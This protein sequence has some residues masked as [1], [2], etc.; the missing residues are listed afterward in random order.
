CRGGY[1]D[2]SGDGQGRKDGMEELALWPEIPAPRRG[3]GLEALAAGQTRPALRSPCLSRIPA[4]QGVLLRDIRPVAQPRLR[5]GS[6]LDR[7]NP[8]HQCGRQRGHLCLER[9]PRESRHLCGGCDLSQG[10]SVYLQDD[11]WEQLPELFAHTWP[12]WNDANL[13]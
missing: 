3:H 9:W 8:S 13:P 1:R 5:H 12:G 10:V 6:S 7:R 11:L 4:I 2:F